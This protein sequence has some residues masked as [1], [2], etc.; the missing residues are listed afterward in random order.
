MSENRVGR[1]VRMTALLLCCLLLS[2]CRGKSET[3][4]TV[5]I[6]EDTAESGPAAKSGTTDEGCWYGW[7]RMYDTSG[8]WA[9][10][11]GYWWDCCAQLCDD[12]S[13]LIW[14]EDLPK[15][16]YLAKLYFTSDG[17]S[18][19][20]TGGSFMD[21]EVTSGDLSMTVTEDKSGRL[22][23]V[24]G[25]YT[26]ENSKGGFRFE[27]FM[28]PWGSIWQCDEDE[29]PYYY[30]DWYLPLIEAGKTM[31]DSIGK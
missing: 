7:W 1:I 25:R 24:S 29:L 5:V 14:D 26:A 31:P 17:D 3:V 20:V 23:T 21:K 28:R 4:K 11:H 13:L 18:F 12:G 16:N 19:T 8:D 2:G 9:R 6:M 30:T 10:M 22:M 15:S 27:I